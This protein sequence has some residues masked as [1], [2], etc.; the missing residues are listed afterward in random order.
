MSICDKLHLELKK[1]LNA[2]CIIKIHLNFYHIVMLNKSISL[3]A[4][5]TF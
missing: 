5:E 2:Y 4:L 3:A 1:I